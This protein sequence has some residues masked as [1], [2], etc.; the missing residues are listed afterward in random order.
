MVVEQ[1]K[2][3]RMIHNRDQQLHNIHHNMST[4]KDE[5]ANKMADKFTDELHNQ[6]KV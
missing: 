4:W 1:G 2:L 3:S 6:L 5:T